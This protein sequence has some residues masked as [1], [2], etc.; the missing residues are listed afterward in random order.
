M[1]KEKENYTAYDLEKEEPRQAGVAEIVRGKAGMAADGGRLD[2]GR[3]D[4]ASADG[5]TDGGPDGSGSAAAEAESKARAEIE[6]MMA[7]MGAEK[8]L[9]IIRENRNA[10]ISQILDEME[11]TPREPMQSGRSVG[12]FCNSIFDL[13]GMA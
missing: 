12:G 5:D 1:E 10:A 11:K 9:E 13:A 7:D 6:A 3:L 4:G 8:L 2:G